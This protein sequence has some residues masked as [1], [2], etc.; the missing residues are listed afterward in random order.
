MVE[1][2]GKSLIF[3]SIIFYPCKQEWDLNGMAVGS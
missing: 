3:L 2:E 1:R